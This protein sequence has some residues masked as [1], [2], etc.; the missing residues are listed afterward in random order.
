VAYRIEFKPRAARDFQ[1][2]AKDAQRR[3]RPRIDA[4]SANPRP[5]GCKK[6]QGSPNR[7]RIR[8]GAYRVIYGV[9]EDVLLV[10]VLRVGQRSTVY[11]QVENL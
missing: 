2:L 8:V 4:L 9:R 7:Y 1:A 6:L 11:R 5:P 10:L 3:I